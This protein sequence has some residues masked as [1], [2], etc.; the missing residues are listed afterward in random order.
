MKQKLSVLIIEDHPMVS[1]VYQKTLE[2]VAKENEELDFKIDFAIDC[3]SAYE[4]LMKVAK[5]EGYDIIFLDI[6][7]PHSKDRKIRSGE[8]LGIKIKKILPEAK[9]IV[10]TTYYDGFRIQSIVK[11]I[12]PDGFLVKN[13]FD[14]QQLKEAIVKVIYEPPYYSNTVLQ[15]FR[16]RISNE[17][18]LDEIDRLMLYELSIGT[19]MNELPD[20]L[21]MSIAGIEKRKR[22]LKEIF[23]V[24]NKGDRDLILK[25]KEKGFI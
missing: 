24:Q 20:V 19:K 12:D 17:H 1:S 5:K 18:I 13:D 23:D 3:D 21:P 15:S 4:K 2:Q 22:Q 8:D 25:A 14:N 6:N 10:S 16:K 9:I 7:L 11:S